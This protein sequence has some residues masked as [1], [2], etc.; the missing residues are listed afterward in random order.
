MCTCP[1]LWYTVNLGVGHG[2][3]VIMMI[4]TVIDF[5]ILT[6]AHNKNMLDWDTRV[7]SKKHNMISYEHLTAI[8]CILLMDQKFALPK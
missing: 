4:K 6:K 5:I 8:Y 3:T 7:R 1:V 2:T